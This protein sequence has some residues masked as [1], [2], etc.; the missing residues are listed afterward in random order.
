MGWSPAQLHVELGFIGIF[1][2]LEGEGAV[3]ILE[4]FFHDL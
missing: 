2:F 3:E 1:I 4:G